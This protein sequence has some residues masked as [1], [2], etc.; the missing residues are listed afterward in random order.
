MGSLSIGDPQMM[1]PL[2]HTRPGRVANGAGRLR[3]RRRGYNPAMSDDVVDESLLR[4]TMCGLELQLIE[5]VER[6]RRA[7]TQGDAGEAAALQPEIDAL[8]VQMAQIS[9]IVA[10]AEGIDAHGP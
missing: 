5:L 4:D 10:A 9:E 6:Q 2:I 3:R 8:H 7:Q 1:L